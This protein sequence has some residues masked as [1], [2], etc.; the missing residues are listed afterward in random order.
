[1]LLS[2]SA[3]APTHAYLCD[4]LSSLMLVSQTHTLSRSRPQ[5]SHNCGSL[6]LT[7][8]AL[9]HALLSHAESCLSLML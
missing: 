4:M 3:D 6:A 5:L 9:P 8:L 2:C 7:C 1:M